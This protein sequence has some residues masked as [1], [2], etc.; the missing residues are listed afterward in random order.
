MSAHVLDTT[1]S[2]LVQSLTLD[3]PGSQGSESPRQHG[4]HAESSGSA[5]QLRRLLIRTGSSEA[6]CGIC[7]ISILLEDPL[8]DTA[9]PK[10]RVS[11]GTWRAVSGTMLRPVAD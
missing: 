6:T 9:I 3:K 8:S 7:H 4:D 1:Y 5:G 11:V 2:Q 10:A